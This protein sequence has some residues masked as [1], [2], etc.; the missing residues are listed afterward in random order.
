MR[1][2]DSDIL[3]AILFWVSLSFIFA[4]VGRERMV[5]EKHLD[6]WLSFLI[7]IIISPVLGLVIFLI[8]P[9]KNK[10]E[11]TYTCK[12]CKYVAKENTVYCPRCYMDEYGLTARDNY[13]KYKTKIV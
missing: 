5:M 1:E 13:E 2:V 9:N 3:F 6:Y 11:I 4:I 10:A 7:C 12:H 8:L